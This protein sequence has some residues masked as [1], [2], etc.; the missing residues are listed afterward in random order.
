MSPM[1]ALRR[2]TTTPRRRLALL[3][4]LLLL[5]AQAQAVAGPPD[6]TGHWAGEIEIPGMPLAAG[7]SSTTSMQTASC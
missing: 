7:R 5:A 1:R 2:Q 3:A 4:S 6:P